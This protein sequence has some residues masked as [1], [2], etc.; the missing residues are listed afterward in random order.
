MSTSMQSMIDDLLAWGGGDDDIGENE[1]SP[2][3]TNGDVDC[4]SGNEQ[5]A[6][7]LL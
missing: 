7:M 5:T 2:Y 1:V 6:S 4:S 3:E